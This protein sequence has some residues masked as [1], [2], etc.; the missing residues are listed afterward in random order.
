MIF[1]CIFGFYSMSRFRVSN[2]LI[3]ARFATWVRI[4]F[5]RL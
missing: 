2:W 5:E 1:M 3:L 4:Q